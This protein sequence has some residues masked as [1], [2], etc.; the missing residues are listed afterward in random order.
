MVL[1]SDLPLQAKV[2]R[3]TTRVVQG[4]AE[5][6]RDQ[7]GVGGGGLGWAAAWRWTAGRQPAGRWTAGAPGTE[8]EIRES[9]DPVPVEYFLR[10][11]NVSVFTFRFGTT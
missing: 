11:G 10:G 3:T 9:P 2:I 6:G 1:N 8:G 5:V 4:V 7:G